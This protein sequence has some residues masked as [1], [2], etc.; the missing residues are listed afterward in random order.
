M[1]ANTL[2]GM[3]RQALHLPMRRRINVQTMHAWKRILETY[4]KRHVTHRIEVFYHRNEVRDLT[5][6]A[7]HAPQLDP[8]G[9][10]VRVRAPDD[11]L[12]EV[13]R[14]LKL[15]ERAVGPEL[16]R[17]LTDNEPNAWF[18]QPPAVGPAS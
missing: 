8:A 3:G 7:E 1:E 4:T 14:L 15:L 17:F 16:P 6:L 11:D 18:T 9:F 13:P 2:L 5:E 10:E 12:G